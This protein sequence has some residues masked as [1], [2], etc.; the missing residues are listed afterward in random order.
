MQ[1]WLNNNTTFMKVIHS[2]IGKGLASIAAAVVCSVLLWLTHG[3]HG[4]GWFILALLFI[5]Q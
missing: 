5:W 1:C 3:E 4:I 2:N